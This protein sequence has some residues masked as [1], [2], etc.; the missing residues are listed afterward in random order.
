MRRQVHE[1]AKK[2]QLTASGICCVVDE[3]QLGE[4]EAAAKKVD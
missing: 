3:P 4:D 2:T 1:D